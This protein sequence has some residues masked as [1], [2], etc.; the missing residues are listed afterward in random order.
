MR[1]TVA[2][3]VAI[4]GLVTASTLPA[5]LRPPPAVVAPPPVAV[6][7]P[8]PIA[9]PDEYARMLRHCLDFE[10][11]K[12]ECVARRYVDLADGRDR[13]EYVRG[14]LYRMRTQHVS[15]LAD[16]ATGS[17]E[18]ARC[19]G[20]SLHNLMLF[21]RNQGTPGWRLLGM[22]TR[23]VYDRGL[24]LAPGDM[25]LQIVRAGL[26]LDLGRVAESDRLFPAPPLDDANLAT[27]DV[28]NMAYYHAARGN[29]VDL[30]VWLARAMRRSPDHTREWAAESD[31]LA[32]F[33]ADSLV[34]AMLKP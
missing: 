26:L 29:R 10:W 12:A 11:K 5:M 9:G 4:L 7:E 25:S 24:H 15:S 23:V 18:C 21:F 22:P 17:L 20:V 27:H 8:A 14:L 32:T 6:Q 34:M 13:T 3:L 16:L 19:A 30:M 2:V 1:R 28:I 33:R 31:D